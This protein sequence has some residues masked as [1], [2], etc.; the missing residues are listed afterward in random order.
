MEF[1]MQINTKEHYDMIEAF[2]TMLKTSPIPASCRFDKE[3]TALWSSG[4]IYQN[5]EVN[6]LFLVY[7]F[8]YARGKQVGQMGFYD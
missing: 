7:R 1:K 8:G 2:E 3:D 4:R 6:N 5:G